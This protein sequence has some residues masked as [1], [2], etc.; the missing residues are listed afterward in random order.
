MGFLSYGS[1]TQLIDARPPP[2]VPHLRAGGRR[3]LPG[4]T[5]SDP[6]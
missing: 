3:G 6:S 4:T 5:G 1:C 2:P